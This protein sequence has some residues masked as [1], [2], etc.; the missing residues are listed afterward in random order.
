MSPLKCQLKENDNHALICK[1]K[2]S[3]Y[4]NKCKGHGKK[5]K[6]KPPTNIKKNHDRILWNSVN[7]QNILK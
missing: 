7:I 6:I 2:G 3:K 5:K 1:L 4:L